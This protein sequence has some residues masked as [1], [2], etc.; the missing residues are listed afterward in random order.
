MN[1]ESHSAADNLRLPRDAAIKLH[2]GGREREAFILESKFRIRFFQ[3]RGDCNP[4][5]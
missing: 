4:A 1:A 3:T 5:N 2:M